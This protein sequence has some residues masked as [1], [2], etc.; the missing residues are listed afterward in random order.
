MNLPSILHEFFAPI[1]FHLFFTTK[2]NGIIHLHRSVIRHIKPPDLSCTI[3]IFEH[4]Q[5]IFMPLCSHLPLHYLPS[6]ICRHTLLCFMTTSE[7]SGSDASFEKAFIYRRGAWHTCIPIITFTINL[8]I[9]DRND[10][11]IRFTDGHRFTNRK[12]IPSLLHRESNPFST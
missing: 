10:G 4:K 11:R 2:T 1:C 9:I 5:L 12:T 8:N 6:V 7:L 3:L